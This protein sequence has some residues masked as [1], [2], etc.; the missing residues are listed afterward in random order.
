MIHAGE[1]TTKEQVYGFFSLHIPGW[2][3]LQNSIWI[4]TSKHSKTTLSLH[5]CKTAFVQQ[6]YALK[7]AV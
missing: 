4:N 5:V 2:P 3:Q 7:L 6:Q 1:K